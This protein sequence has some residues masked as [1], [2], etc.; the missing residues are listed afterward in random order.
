MPPGRSC[1]PAGSAPLSADGSPSALLAAATAAARRRSVRAAARAAVSAAIV[2]PVFSPRRAGVLA[3]QVFTSPRCSREGLPEPPHLAHDSRLGRPRLRWPCLPVRVVALQIPRAHSV[4]SGRAYWSIR[5]W[6]SPSTTSAPAS[7][8]GVFPIVIVMPRALHTSSARIDG[9]PVSFDE[10]SGTRLPAARPLRLLGVRPARVSSGVPSRPAAAPESL[11]RVDFLV[12]RARVPCLR[13]LLSRARA[14]VRP[15]RHLSSVPRPASACFLGCVVRSL[16][17]VGQLHLRAGSV[18]AL[19]RRAPQCACPL[20]QALRASLGDS[21]PWST[22]RARC[23]CRRSRSLR[24][25]CDSCS[26]QVE[27]GKSSPSGGALLVWPPAL[28]A[29]REGGS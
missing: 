29:A 8:V 19:S 28:A 24:R 14:P 27:W 9:R 17:G 5:Q 1:A 2:S 15:R 20:L 13:S 10:R 3:A 6:S 4:R 23:S 11:F 25:A 26:R 7:P 12:V 21:A 18:G 16:S 22:G